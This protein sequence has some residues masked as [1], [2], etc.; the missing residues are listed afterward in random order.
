[1]FSH[2]HLRASDLERAWA[3]YQRVLEPLGLVVKFADTDRGWAGWR[4]PGEERPL[5]LVGRPVDGVAHVPGNGQMVALLAPSRGAV[6][7]CHAIA[8][9]L[10]ATDEGG[11]GPRPEYHAACYGAYFRDLDG[12][13]VCVCCHETP[14]TTGDSRGRD[15][16]GWTIEVRPATGADAGCLAALVV[17]VFL[18]A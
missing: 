7:R 12:N 10:G 15:P 11:P 16:V 5:L 8:L 1:M 9:E 2:V 3:F 14:P 13:K 4:Q 17:Q 18:L 6:K